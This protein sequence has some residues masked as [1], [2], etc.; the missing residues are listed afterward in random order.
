MV[1]YKIFGA[2]R[3]GTNFLM[4]LLRMNVKDVEVHEN[5][6]GSKHDVP[7][8][9]GKMEMW[10]KGNHFQRLEKDM[11]VRPTIV[12][13]NPYSWFQSILRWSNRQGWTW[14][15]QKMYNRYQLLYFSYRDLLELGH[16]LYGPAIF[17]RYEDL[18]MDPKGQLERLD[19][20]IKEAITLPYKVHLS[21]Q[22]TDQRKFF[23]LSNGPFGLNE[24]KA[25]AIDNI[26]DWRLM[27]Y[28]GYKIRDWE[29]PQGPLHIPSST[30]DPIP[31]P[32]IEFA[33]DKIPL[34]SWESKV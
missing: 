21:D 2:M 13:K 31:N 3:T 20:P 23:Y 12:I 16:D 29:A 32:E 19:V 4:N 18:L 33:R 7:A 11:D 34:P 26:M 22:F 27:E 24:P 15:F 10:S 28:Y 6:W 30:S 14:D 1:R 25:T 8:T 17:F 9:K 5:T